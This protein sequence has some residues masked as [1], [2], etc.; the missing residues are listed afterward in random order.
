ML[1]TERKKMDFA[2]LDGTYQLVM[3]R[4]EGTP[5]RLAR[6]LEGK[7]NEL[8][9]RKPGGKWSAQEHAGHLLTM[10]SLWIARLDDYVLKHETL[11]PWNGT[12]ADTDAALYN[13]HNIEKILEDFASIRV[14]MTTMLRKYTPQAETMISFDPRLQVPMRLLDHAWII[15]EHDDHH[16]ATI[17][18]RL[19]TV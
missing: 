4:I 2:L 7:T 9:M 13:L 5:L 18:E 16:L 14:S 15:A 19:H 10:E 6:K 3:E 11:R 1:W 12:N 8:L 17:H